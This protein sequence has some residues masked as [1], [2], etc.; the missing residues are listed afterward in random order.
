MNTAATLTPTHQETANIL[1]MEDETTVAKGLEMV[2]SEAG[3]QVALAATGHAA[4]NTMFTKQFDLMVADLRLP[5]MDGLD[6]IK[7]VKDKWPDTEVVVITGYSSVNSVVTSM[8][9]GAYDYLAK[10]FTDDQ[11]K[12]SIRCALGMKEE[13]QEV[14][15]PKIVERVETEEEKLIQKR[16][17][18]RV[19]NRTAEDADFWL[20][21]MEHGSVAL[22][23]YQLS[24]E[25]RAAITSGDLNWINTHVGELTQKQLMFIFK[26]LEREAW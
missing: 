10:P 4:L 23:E 20:D 22:A 17:V 16:E 18:I 25:A 13:K 21:L 6:V 3:Y 7:Q 2:L 15:A 26:R 14:P 9:L 8:K 19:L 5:D 12:D 1:V 11:I 24:S